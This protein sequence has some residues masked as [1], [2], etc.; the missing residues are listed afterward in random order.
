MN[1]EQALKELAQIWQ[2]DGRYHE[3]ALNE[4]RALIEK[5]YEGEKIH[6]LYTVPSIWLECDE[7]GGSGE[8]KELCQ[9][10]GQCGDDCHNPSPQLNPCVTGPCTCKDGKGEWRVYWNKP[11]E[12]QGAT[13]WEKPLHATD[14]IKDPD[15]AYGWLEMEI[16]GEKQYTIPNNKGR[17]VLKEVK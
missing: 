17:L 2:D 9:D 12:H 6:A 8:K 14:I 7:C 4:V 1:K 10:I 5:I 15:V 11:A 3:K 13:G 16:H